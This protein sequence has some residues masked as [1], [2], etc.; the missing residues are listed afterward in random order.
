MV[1]KLYVGNLPWTL[2]TDD[3][4]DLFSEHGKV[5]DAIVLAD[6]ETGRS[7]GFG[8]VEMSTL[9][10]GDRAIEALNGADIGGRPL[11]VNEAQARK[12]RYGDRP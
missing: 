6:R 5:L 4:H 11:R 2:D 10:E 9:E 8:F 7:R 3:L 1:K 12:P